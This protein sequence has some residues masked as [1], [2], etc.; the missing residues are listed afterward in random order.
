[1]SGHPIDVAQAGHVGR[2]HEEAA[3]GPLGELHV[4]LREGDKAATVV[5]PRKGVIERKAPH[6]DLQTPHLNGVA[7]APRQERR[8]ELPLRQVVLGAGAQ[9]LGR[10][11]VLVQA[12]E[13]HHRHVRVT[14]PDPLERFEPG[15]LRQGEVEQD[16]VHAALP[17]SVEALGETGCVR[18]LVG[19]R[20]RERHTRLADRVLQLPCVTGIVLDQ[21]DA[22]GVALDSRQRPPG[23]SA[24]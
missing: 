2:D 20:S 24:G 10:Q 13:C 16:D 11:V 9:G 7:D 6:P 5:E 19:R 22:D 15:C 14:F 12:R 18:E 21:Q 4:R 8:A 1:M 17:E 23:Q 3:L